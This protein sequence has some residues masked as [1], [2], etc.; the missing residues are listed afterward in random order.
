MTGAVSPPLIYAPPAFFEIDRITQ[1]FRRVPFMLTVRSSL[2]LQCETLQP[3]DSP[4][5]LSG[6]KMGGSVRC[7]T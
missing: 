3:I 4:P 1:T 5:E 7:G 2:N 6:K